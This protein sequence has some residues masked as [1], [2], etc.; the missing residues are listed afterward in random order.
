MDPSENESGRVR[1]FFPVP[2]EPPPATFLG[3]EG[4]ALS[5]M[6]TIFKVKLVQKQLLELPGEEGG[7]SCGHR[8][9]GG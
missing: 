3:F 8:F 6:Q 9:A 2:L 5:K 1:L 7:G 4:R